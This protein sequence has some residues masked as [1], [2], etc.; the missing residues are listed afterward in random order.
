MKGG[1]PILTI[2]LDCTHISK[3]QLQSNLIEQISIT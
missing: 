1:L 3:F 2:Y